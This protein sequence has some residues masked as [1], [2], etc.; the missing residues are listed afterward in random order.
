MTGD[1]DGTTLV[2]RIKGGG[3]NAFRAG[4]LTLEEVRSLVQID[5][6]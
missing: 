4:R 5:Q 6:F 1:P 2:M 3:L